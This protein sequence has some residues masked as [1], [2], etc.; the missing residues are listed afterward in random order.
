MLQ[1]LFKSA[2]DKQREKAAEHFATGMQNIQD[3]FFNKAMIEFTKALELD[4]E[5]MHKKMQLELSNFTASGDLNAALAVGMNLLNAD[6]NNF[7]LANQLGNFAR[8]QKDYKQAEGLYKM[9][10]RANKQFDIAYINLAAS[11]ARVEYYDDSARSAV[12][13]FSNVK[14]FVIPDFI[15]DDDFLKKM[16]E[17]IQ[18]EKA[19]KFAE[20]KQNLSQAIENAKINDEELEVLELEAKLKKGEEAVDKVSF[21][22]LN[23]RFESLQENETGERKAVIYNQI[24]YAI[25][26]NKP[27]IAL[28]QLKLLTAKDFEVVELLY[29]LAWEQK[30]KPNMAVKKIT[31]MLGKNEF[32]RYNNVNLGLIYRRLGKG[33]LANKYL[34][35]TA[36]L[37]E[38][39]GGLYSMKNLVQQAHEL[40]DAGELRKALKFYKIA[41]TE[42]P[43]QKIL[44][45]MGV[46]FVDTKKYDEAIESFRKIL[47]IDPKSEVANAKL[48]E[49][50]DY[51]RDKG[52]SL[53]RD[54]KFQ[55][56][57][58][59]M[60]K[61]L[62]V[63]RLPDTIKQAATIYREMK[64]VDKERELM[65]EWNALMD[66]ARIETQEKERQEKVVEGKTLL[67]Q[68]DYMGAIDCFE[69]AFRMALDKNVF[70]Q[71]AAIYKGLR[72]NKALTDLVTR[73]ENMVAHEEKMKRYAKDEA[74]AQSEG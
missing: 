37:L 12:E 60:Y 49:I 57:V 28:K 71:L 31:A 39:S 19:R 61:A 16:S 48:L 1:D 58:D 69:A 56:A 6:R 2:E 73:W 41:S 11:A 24:L 42:I 72:K 45:N 63:L 20:E 8:R 33:F 29:A 5:G 34:I 67:K 52:D 40:F 30:G 55:P 65:E 62:D 36:F 44:E 13:K 14:G 21:K 51:Y 32:N 7:K 23:R 4:R 26:K 35:K 50:H 25:E 15:G 17:E 47:A 10:I 53:L 18:I 43:D 27:D 22:D 66:Q 59:Y 46:I 9:A 54:R 70:L 38:K 64:N 3:K 68:K 74:R